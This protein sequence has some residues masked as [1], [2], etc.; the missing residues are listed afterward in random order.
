MWPYIK[1]QDKLC[2]D[3]HCMQIKGIQ[4]I[5]E[6]GLPVFSAVQMQLDHSGQIVPGLKGASDLLKI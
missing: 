4:T 3:Y 6:G 5:S 1:A 2:S